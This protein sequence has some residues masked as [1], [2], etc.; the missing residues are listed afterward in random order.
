MQVYIGNDAITLDKRTFKG[1]GGEG[2][3]HKVRRNGSAVG[4]KVYEK[5]TRER[6][7]KLLAFMRHAHTFNDRIIAPQEL[8]FNSAGSVVGYTY[9][10][11]HLAVGFTMPFVDGDFAEIKKLSNRNYRKSYGI[12]SKDVGLIFLDGL[13]TLRDVIHGQGFVVGD[14]SDLNEIAQGRRMIFWDVDAWQFDRFPC[15]VATLDFVDPA[16]YGVELS[17]RPVFSPNND[18]YSFAVMLF[19]SL[20]LVH[21]Y[22]GSH[23]SIDNLLNRAAKRITVFDRDVTYPVIGIH[24]DILTD[25]MH[26]VFNGYFAKGQRTPFPEKVLHDYVDSLRECTSCGTYFP[27]NRGSC[28]VCSAKMVVVVQRPTSSAKDMD[29]VELIKVDGDILFSEVVGDEIRLLSNYKG[30]I[31]YYAKDTRNPNSPV[32]RKD[33]F[34]FVPGSKFEVGN[35]NVF[36]NYPGTDEILVYSVATGK[37]IG[38]VGTAVFAPTRKAVF[39][40]S[41]E[42]FFRIDGTDLKYGKMNGRSLNEKTLRSVMEDQT[43]FWADPNADEPYVFGLFQVLKQQMFWLVKDGRYFDVV[44][45][46]LEAGE[47]LTDIAVKFSSQGVYL[48][49]KTQLKGANYLRQEMVDSSGKVIFTNRMEESR[50]PEPEIHGL[51][52]STGQALHATDKGVLHEKVQTGETRLF[53]STVGFVDGGDTLLRHGA[54]ILA[55]KQDKVLLIT[56]K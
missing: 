38:K 31:I 35:D 5:P 40:A 24:P 43:W 46:Q 1:A 6:A 55:V 54:S 26:N 25:D 15:P 16:L 14:L 19:K 21:P 12:T 8:V 4:L 2:S 9:D 56:P 51:A 49:R 45:P 3:V 22:G 52:Y 34:T 39:R 27:G 30:R 13:P 47:S 50:H 32:T 29:I 17:Q 23:K 20:L 28:P 10:P 18:W 41:G 53:A 11:N 33:L 7:E 48:L 37:L 44:I 36:V 42:Y